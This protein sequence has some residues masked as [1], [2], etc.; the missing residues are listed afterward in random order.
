MVQVRTRISRIDWALVPPYVLFFLMLFVPTSYQPVKGALLLI[1]LGE[2][3]IWALSRW[4]LALDRSVFLWTVFFAALGLGFMLRGAFLGA[5]GALRVGTVYVLWPVVY[6]VLITGLTRERALVG[7]L[8]VLVGSAI[9]VSLYALSYILYAAGWLPGFLYLPL[10]QGQN[11]GFYSGWIEISLYSLSSLVF[12]VPFLVAALFT[13]PGHESWPVSRPMLWMAFLLGMAVVVLSGRRALLLVVL[14]APGLALLLRMLQSLPVRRSNRRVVLRVLAGGGVLLF[15]LA[16]YL[17]SVYDLRLDSLVEMVSEGFQFD[18]DPS[19]RA[20]K[21]QFYALLAGWEESPILGAGHGAALPSVVR[22]A[23]MPWAF[24]LSYV[25]LLYQTGLAGFLAYASGVVWIF[26]MGM[27]IVRSNDR[28]GRY[29]LPV[30][31]GTACF[32]LANASNPYLG[33]YDFLW[34]LFL[35]IGI[36]NSWLLRRRKALPERVRESAWAR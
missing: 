2:V 30:L 28:L 29:M 34:V 17:H 5:P 10:D 11:I 7:L 3:A 27:R 1:V 31:V 4:R 15:A 26:W 6:A 8:R 36:I 20:R 22:S 21:Q 14:L 13:W 33:K 23:E 19:G 9:A 18:R 32:L 12:L 35:P 16:A 24:E 25:A